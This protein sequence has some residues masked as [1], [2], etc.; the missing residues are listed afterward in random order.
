MITDCD[1]WLL[2]VFLSKI[3][4]YFFNHLWCGL[5]VEPFILTVFKINIRSEAVLHVC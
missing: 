4:C 1:I 3:I 5:E 2:S